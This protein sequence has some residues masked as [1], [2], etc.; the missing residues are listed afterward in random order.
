[1]LLTLKNYIEADDLEDIVNK[2]LFSKGVTYNN[3]PFNPFR[4]IEDEKIIYR[5]ES[6]DDDNIRGVLLNAPNRSGI[7]INS[8]RCLRSKRFIATH[9]LMHY[10]FHPKYDRV[11]CFEK[12]DELRK[13]KEWQANHAAACALMPSYLMYD[14][15]E[16]S[17]GNIDYMCNFF[18]VT[19][20]AMMYRMNTLNLIRYEYESDYIFYKESIDNTLRLL[21]SNWL[22]G[23]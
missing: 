8:N 3:Y 23:V 4:L 19:K 22:Y 17:C 11:V 2:L 1:M 7:L 10:W 20:E 9:E 13:G 14:T 12:Y 15:F 16:S 18:Q 21:E 6:F 5:E